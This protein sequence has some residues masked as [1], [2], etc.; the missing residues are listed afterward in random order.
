MIG[1]AGLAITL[2]PVLSVLLLRGWLPHPERNPLT[3]IQNKILLGLY[4]PIIAGSLLF[5]P[6]V[7]P[8]IV[9]G[10]AISAAVIYPRIS[11]EFMPPLN[12]GD[13]LYMPVLQPGASLTEAQRVMSEQDVLI[14]TIP[15]VERV[16]GKAGR[17]ET[18]TDP[19]P[20]TMFETIIQLRDP[21]EWRP[22]VTRQDI[23]DEII[24]L[25]RMPGLSPIMTQP[26][27][28]RVDM[29][30]TGIQT[31]VGV[32]V[33][34]DDIQTI[35]DLAVRIEEVAR[36]VPGAVGPYAE[37]VGSR[38]YLEIDID[39]EVIAR[40]GLTIDDVQ[41]VIMSALGGMNVTWTVEGRERYPIRIRYPRELRDRIESLVGMHPLTS[42]VGTFHR[43]SLDLQEGG[44]GV[45]V[46]DR[47]PQAA[48]RHAQ[49]Q[50]ADHDLR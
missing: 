9:G 44:I 5:G 22:G 35:E 12:E 46:T 37:R 3:W 28:N 21:A 45:S 43:L 16:V 1:S 29:L 20:I 7:V 15:E 42:F 14:S 19:A 34:G 49:V 18:P 48:Q 6:L 10:L 50:R 38:P 11:S 41:M 24:D 30:A 33:F 36:T 27:Q 8:L 26:I 13:L 39:R 4:R 40:H 47:D 17:A 31:P 23:I 25:T 32:K 2:L